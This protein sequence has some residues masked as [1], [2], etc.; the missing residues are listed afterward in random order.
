MIQSARVA[1]REDRMNSDRGWRD[2]RT[3]RVSGFR[4]PEQ[5]QNFLIA[6]ALFCD[7]PGRAMRLCAARNRLG[8]PCRAAAMRNSARCIRHIGTAA[9]RARLAAYLSGDL[10]RIQRSEMR[11]QRNALR[12]TWRNDPRVVGKTILLIPDDERACEEWAATEGLSLEILDHDFPAFADAARW[13]WVRRGLI[14][15]EELATKIARL[16]NRIAEAGHAFD[17]S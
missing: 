6:R 13:I 8:E 9:K 14:C 3:G 15:D 10:D 5:R 1:Y 2:P 4:S 7:G 11:I 17:R 12:V 16:R